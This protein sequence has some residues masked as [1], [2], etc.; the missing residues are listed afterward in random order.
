MEREKAEYIDNGQI[1]K[2][3]KGQIEEFKLDPPGEGE[4]QK[5][6][7]QGKDMFQFVPDGKISR[8]G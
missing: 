7:K 4:P 2:G 1:K 6:W 8:K 3:L 5:V